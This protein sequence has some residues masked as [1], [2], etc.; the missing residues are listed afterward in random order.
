MARPASAP[1]AAGAGSGKTSAI[2]GKLAY[3]MEQRAIPPSDILVLA[4]NA[5]VAAELRER[6]ESLGMP[7]PEVSTFHAKGFDILGAAFGRKPA[8]SALATDRT[9]LQRFLAVR[10]A[11]RMRDR[12]PDALVEYATMGREI[13]RRE[14]AA[15]RRQPIRASVEERAVRNEPCP[16]GSGRKFKKCCGRQAH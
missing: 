6:I 14:M 11:A 3:L 4:F 13:G 10:F 9:A 7:L 16:C 1:Q 12:G 2:L 8:V 15:R 5:T